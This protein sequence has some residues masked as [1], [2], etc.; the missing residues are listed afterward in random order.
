VNIDLIKAFPKEKTYTEKQVNVMKEF[1]HVELAQA[2]QQKA[3][4][5]QL[6]IDLTESIKKKNAEIE[7][8][9]YFITSLTLSLK[10]SSDYVVKLRS[11]LQK[12]E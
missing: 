1:H 7:H 12:F 11:Q 4:A 5:Q 2:Y 6:V 9:E 8:L 10:L 3:R